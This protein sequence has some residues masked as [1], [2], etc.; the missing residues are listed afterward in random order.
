MQETVIT[1]ESGVIT[2]T[3]ADL[4]VV[5]LRISASWRDHLNP[6]E[7][8]EAISAA[9]RQALPPRGQ[10]A[11]PAVPEVHLPLSSIPAYLAEMREGRAAM[12]RYLARL[13]AGEVDHRRAE[14]LSTP[15]DRV[16]VFLVGGRFHSL[17]INPEWAE[18]AALQSLSDEILDALPN[19]LVR[20][21]QEDPDI[22]AAQR[23]YAAARRH[24]IEK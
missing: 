23:H 16:E 22:A 6:R 17:Q 19:P 9:I 10:E 13:R 2:I 15:R 20:P 14:V 5:S 8:A 7:L 21:A 18:K 3:V 24:L 4:E 12:R 11:P 1:D